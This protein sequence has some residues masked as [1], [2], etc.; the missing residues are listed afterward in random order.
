MVQDLS[1]LAMLG[2]ENQLQ[3]KAVQFEMVKLD[4]AEE[5]SSSCG[6]LLAKVNGA[7]VDNGK[8]AKEMRDRAY[9][10][11]KQAVDLIREAGCLVFWKDEQIAEQ[12]ASAYF[13]KL[14]EA[15]EKKV[16]EEA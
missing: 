11:L 9:T 15:R 1:E 3:L 14:R 5:L 8:L 7:R 16:D 4:R 13:R 10:Y 6:L 2:K 12:Y